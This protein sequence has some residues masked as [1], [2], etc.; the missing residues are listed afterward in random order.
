MQ[1]PLRATRGCIGQVKYS[2]VRP[3]INKVWHHQ[4]AS[5]RLLVVRGE[6]ARKC[7]GM[8][9]FHWERVTG[10]PS[11]TFGLIAQTTHG[12]FKNHPGKVLAHDWDHKPSCLLL[13]LCTPTGY[14]HL[15]WSIESRWPVRYPCDY[16]TCPQYPSCLSAN[17]RMQGALP[18]Q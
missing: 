14:R 4:N 7:G 12:T 2:V 15:S 1:G 6:P 3:A 16:A 10:N 17:A 11:Q 5:T 9:D 13:S 18:R 8:S